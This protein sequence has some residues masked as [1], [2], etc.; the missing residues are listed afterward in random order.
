[1]GYMQRFLRELNT[2]AATGQSETSTGRNLNF[3]AKPQTLLSTK[4]KGQRGN[5]ESKRWDQ[6]LT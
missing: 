3:A 2:T 4:E 1:M 6:K 5:L